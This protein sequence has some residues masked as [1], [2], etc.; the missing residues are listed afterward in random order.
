MN[1]NRRE[2]LLDA[3]SQ[4]NEVIDTIREVQD[5]EQEA[6]DNMPEGFQ[7]GSRGEAMQEAIDV[8]D[9]FIADV[10]SV[11]SDIENFVEG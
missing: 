3:A 9:G 6:F 11:Q 4:L 8:M 7:V 2:R 10:E 1:R 5:E